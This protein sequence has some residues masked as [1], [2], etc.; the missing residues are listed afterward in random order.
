MQNA[1]SL[2]GCIFVYRRFYISNTVPSVG[3][4]DA[5]KTALASGQH[6]I[7]IRGRLTFDITHFKHG[8][9]FDIFHPLHG[10]GQTY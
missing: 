8:A 3:L 7:G 5:F 2:A 4:R 6:V 1:L 9:F 10:H